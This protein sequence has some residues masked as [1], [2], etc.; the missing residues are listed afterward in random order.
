MGTGFTL[1][2]TKAEL[3]QLLREPITVYVVGINGDTETSEPVAL[4][5]FQ[6]YEFAPV[7]ESVTVVLLHTTLADE[8]AVTVGIWLTTWLIVTLPVHP[9]FLVARTV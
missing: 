9:L 4:P 2:I 1:C 7:A 5:G 6:V 3:V 8:S